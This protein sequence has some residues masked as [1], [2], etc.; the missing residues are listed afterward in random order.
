MAMLVSKSKI[1]EDNLRMYQV[2]IRGIKNEAMT[3]QQM[4]MERGLH[5]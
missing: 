2:V 1:K 5:R 3:I 4:I